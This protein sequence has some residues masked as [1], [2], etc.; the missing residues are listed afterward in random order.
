MCS[1]PPYDWRDWDTGRSAHVL[2]GGGEQVSMVLVPWKR[3]YSGK[4]AYNSRAESSRITP[5]KWNGSR[6]S[7]QELDF[8][9]IMF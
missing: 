6:E 4:W 2:L 7:L 9:Y 5:G 3:C 8:V 1:I